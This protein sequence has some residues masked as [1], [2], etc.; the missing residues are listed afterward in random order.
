MH[1]HIIFAFKSVS[2]D[3]WKP[4]LFAFLPMCFFRWLC[5]SADAERVAGAAQAGRRFE[6]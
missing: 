3:R 5:D 1:P 2:V 6:G 4:V